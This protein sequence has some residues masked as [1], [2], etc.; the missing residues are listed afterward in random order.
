MLGQI[1]T[2]VE[3]FKQ[4]WEEEIADAA[5]RSAMTEAGH[6]WR[7]RTLDP[8]TTFRLFTLQILFEQEKG[9]S[10]NIDQPRAPE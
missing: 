6:K 4:N 8:V 7:K 2:I 5:I 3:Q 1:A 10:P 9:I